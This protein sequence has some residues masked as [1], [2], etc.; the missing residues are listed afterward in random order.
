MALTLF[1][2]ALAQAVVALIALIVEARLPWK[3][4]WKMVMALNGFFVAL[5]VGSALLFRRAKGIS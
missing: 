4:C 3:Q 2:M 5:W 1:A